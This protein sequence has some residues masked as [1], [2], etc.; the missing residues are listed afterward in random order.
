MM[1]FVSSIDHR[2][3]AEFP[4]GKESGKPSGGSRR[5]RENLNVKVDQPCGLTHC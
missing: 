1:M 5:G 4:L 3:G 2:A